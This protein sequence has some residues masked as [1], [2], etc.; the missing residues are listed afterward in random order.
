[1]QGLPE[2]SSGIGFY[3]LLGIG[4]IHAIEATL[5]SPKI[6][7][8]ILHLHPVLVLAVLVIGEHLFGLWGL[9]L[10]VLWLRERLKAYQAFGS[11]LPIA[12]VFTIRLQSGV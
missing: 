5:L 8:K 1:M 11:L 3:A 6:V 2:I 7:G 12:G 10:G 9:L 4:V